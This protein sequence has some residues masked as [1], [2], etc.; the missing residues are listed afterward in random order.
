M[1]QSAHRQFGQQR[2]TVRQ[3]TVVEDRAWRVVRRALVVDADINVPGRD[4]NTPRFIVR[5]PAL[6]SPGILI[7]E[8]STSRPAT[9]SKDITAES[10][11]T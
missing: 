3:D 4:V 6:L 1:G 9:S 8:G 2:G 7:D 10:H 5:L 11:F